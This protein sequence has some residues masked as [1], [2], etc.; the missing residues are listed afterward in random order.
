MLDHASFGLVLSGGLD[1]GTAGVEV[2][3]HVADLMNVT[4]V[5]P[6]GM[7]KAPARGRLTPGL[8]AGIDE[9]VPQCTKEEARRQVSNCRASG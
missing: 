5:V 7:K 3:G 9:P 2:A 4:A 8:R 1:D 6:R